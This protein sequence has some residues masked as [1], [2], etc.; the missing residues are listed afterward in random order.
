MAASASAVK[1]NDQACVCS[2]SMPPGCSMGSTA[3]GQGQTDGS[4]PTVAP[5][6]GI[7][8]S[9]DHRAWTAVPATSPSS[10]AGH[11]GQ[12]LARSQIAPA[13]PRPSASAAGWTASRLPRLG[14]EPK[15]KSSSSGTCASTT[16]SA[17]PFMNPASTGC[18]TTRARRARPNKAK[19]TCKA[20]LSSSA[21][22]H[23][24]TMP[25]TPPALAGASRGSTT[26]CATRVAKVSAVAE[27]GPE[28]GTLVRPSAPWTRPPMLAVTKAAS[29]ATCGAAAPSGEKASNPIV[30]TRG[31]TDS[32]PV[33]PANVSL[34]QPGPALPSSLRCMVCRLVKVTQC[35]RSI[36]A[37]PSG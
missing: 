32:A 30:R 3:G 37:P 12:R 5:P 15:G 26:S 17:A 14:W 27:V 21:S 34:I 11:R 10:A 25:S 1:A 31:S 35:R 6:A 18:G 4:R 23:R 2:S 28:T 19:L 7:P 36:E 13:V 22:P 20:P 33:H 16:S 9:D 29:R 24:A 8:S